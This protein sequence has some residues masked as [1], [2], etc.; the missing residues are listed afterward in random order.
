MA[1][2]IRGADILPVTSNAGSCSG[3]AS[4]AEPKG[5]KCRERCE[6]RAVLQDD[7]ELTVAGGIPSWLGV[8]IV[9]APVAAPVKRKT[10][11]NRE[12]RPVE[13]LRTLI[14][15]AL[16]CNERA[17]AEAVADLSEADGM[18]WISAGDSLV[19]S[20]LVSAVDRDWLSASA[21]TLVTSLSTV[22]GMQDA[23][24]SIDVDLDEEIDFGSGAGKSPVWSMLVPVKDGE[25][26][27]GGFQLFGISGSEPDTVADLIHVAALAFSITANLRRQQKRLDQTSDRLREIGEVGSIFAAVGERER[28][29]SRI[30]E[31]AKLSSNAEIGAIVHRDSEGNLSATGVEMKNLG[32]IQFASGKNLLERVANLESEFVLTERQMAAELSPDSI[33]IVTLAAFPLVHEATHYGAMVLINLPSILLA[34]TTYISTMATISCLAASAITSE[35][36][37]AQKLEQQ[38]IN[39]DL[40]SGR[41]VQQSLMPRS[42]PNIKGLEVAGVSKPF[43]G[44]GG[45]FYD[46][47]PLG[48]TVLSVMQGDVSGKGIPAGLMMAM[49]HAYL[50]VVA[51]DHSDS[52][53]RTMEHLNRL[54]CPEFADNKF[55]TAAYV[56]F[57]VEKRK[58]VLA[59]AGHHPPLLLKP[60]GSVEEIDS[61]GLPLGIL[62]DAEYDDIEFP[63][64][65]GT[66]LVVFTDGLVEVMNEQSELLDTEG[67]MEILRNKQSLSA[68]DLLDHLWTQTTSFGKIE[69]DWTAMVIRY[70]A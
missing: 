23:P 40:E 61:G 48:E 8:E 15:H 7:G 14:E 19:S 38:K 24:L 63:F 70:S 67:M 28:T 10:G 3:S 47:L 36:R 26:C 66:T 6:H 59:N 44:I 54:L 68:G 13:Y 4:E 17:I 16:A 56:I 43:R 2:I 31:L 64:E 50:R 25:S 45:D 33:P 46:V 52:S 60:D 20:C 18:L 27:L 42:V 32:M 5:V 21:E 11:F 49:A 30:L 62:E 34:D 39:Q 41:M 55:I 53:A 35:E 29:I 51:K 69:D 37:Q 1:A 22:H 58:A 65:P 57:D 12:S 9:A